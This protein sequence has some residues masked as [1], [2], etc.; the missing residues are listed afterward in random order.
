MHKKHQKAFTLVELLLSL[1]IFGM[2]MAAVAVAFDASVKNYQDNQGIYRTIN[3]AR[4]TLLRL[5]NDIRTADKDISVDEDDDHLKL[6]M[7]HTINNSIQTKT[8]RFD[9]TSKNLYLNTGDSE[10]LIMLGI[11]NDNEN[12]N[13]PKNR[14]IVDDLKITPGHVNGE[15]RNVRIVMTVTDP[16]SGVSQTLAAAA[17]VRRNL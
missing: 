13:K 1:A 4:Q 15:I 17:V 11:E 3:A 14:G 2:L 12:D 9:K 7:S 6:T 16:D 5:T 8:Y 10:Y